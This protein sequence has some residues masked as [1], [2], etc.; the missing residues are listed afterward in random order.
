MTPLAL[1]EERP[2]EPVEALLVVPQAGGG[3]GV[4]RPLRGACPPTWLVTGVVFGGRESRFADPAPTSLDELVD[5]VV[6]AGTELAELTGRPPVLVGQC[7][8]GLLAWLSADRLSAR[9]AAPGGLVVVSRPAPGLAG[10]LPDVTAPDAEFLADVTR[11]GGVPEEIA[12]MPELLE[13]LLPSLRA[14]FAAIG[15]WT[16]VDAQRVPPRHL[17]ALVLHG[18]DDPGCTASAVRGWSEHLPGCRINRVPGTHFLLG[19]TPRGVAEE[20]AAWRGTSV[21]ADKEAGRCSN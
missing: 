11:L 3:A 8:G 13:L 10:T 21:P 17:P 18:D 5:D 6:T 7:S 14:D 2:S 15:Q 1:P 4:A 16:A 20:I 19:A 9:G 12:A